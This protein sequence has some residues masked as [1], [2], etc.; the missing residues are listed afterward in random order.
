MGS[1]LGA[2]LEAAGP[3]GH[4]GEEAKGHG[5]G[6]RGLHGR[7]GEGRW[8]L[9]RCRAVGERGLWGPRG[10]WA[11]WMKGSTGPLGCGGEG[12]GGRGGA[13]QRGDGLRH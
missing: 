12:A 2:G 11:G 1:R 4:G 13:V 5:E 9:W 8:C 6:R 3:R 10:R 7:G